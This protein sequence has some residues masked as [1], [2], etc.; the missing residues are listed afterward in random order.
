MRVP[1]I[2]LTHEH[3]IGAE[4]GRS[5]HDLPHV[6]IT[7]SAEGARRFEELTASLVRRRMAI[8]ID[9]RVLTAPTVQE[10]IGGGRAMIT[11]GSVS[12]EEADEEAQALA[13]ILGRGALDCDSWERVDGRTFGAAP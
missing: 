6:L 4:V 13:A 11:L 2:E 9:G 3:L 8:L 1:A 12:D 5:E 10:R 7:F